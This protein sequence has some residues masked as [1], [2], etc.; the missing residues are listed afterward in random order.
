MRPSRPAAFA[1]LIGSL[2]SVGCLNTSQEKEPLVL[3]QDTRSVLTAPG[4]GG[5]S[6]AKAV[7]PGSFD[8]TATGG[9]GLSVQNSFNRTTPGAGTS[10][11]TGNFASNLPPSQVGLPPPV[12]A[13]AIQGASYGEPMT[14]PGRTSMTRA[15]TPPPSP[16]ADASPFGPNPPKLDPPLN[17]PP[18]PRPISTLPTPDTSGP[19]R[20]VM[21]DLDRG[22]LPAPA[23]PTPLAPAAPIPLAS[24]PVPGSAANEPL[25]LMPAPP[26]YVPSPTEAP[27]PGVQP[28]PKLPPAPPIRPQ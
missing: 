22:P 15:A 3:G 11:S 16:P 6:S 23:T 14:E 18:P 26:T 28:P 20:P 27:I 24:P 17:D 4:S 13:P 21:P 12:M 10:T 9:S 8:P 5:A 25:P 7:K 1:V 2:A 19:I